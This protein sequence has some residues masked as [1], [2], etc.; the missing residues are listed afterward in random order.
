MGDGT[1]S[2]KWKDQPVGYTVIGTIIDQPK[3]EQMTDYHD[4]TKLLFWPSNDPMMQIVCTIQTDMRDPAN[5][6]DDGKRRLHIPPRMQKPVR[7]AVQKTGAKGLA[8]GGRIAVQRTGGTG[9]SGSPFEFA[10]EYAPPAVDPGSILGANGNGAAAQPAAAA[11]PQPA[12]P[13]VLGVATQPLGLSTPATPVAA[14]APD[15]SAA[16]RS[17]GLNS[18]AT[19]LPCPPSVDPAKWA[20]LPPEQQQAVL[21]AMAQP[22]F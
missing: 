1:K 12:A 4:K 18:P 3:V 22:G 21:A 17:L 5:A 11:V 16:M 19:P 14:A 7:E 10:A 8:I 13:A 20:V 9:E 15:V 2:I 6:E